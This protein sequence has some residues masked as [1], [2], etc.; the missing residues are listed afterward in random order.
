MDS[1]HLDLCRFWDGVSDPSVLGIHSE[2]P[3]ETLEQNIKD[4]VKLNANSLRSLAPDELQRRPY[5][6][7]EISIWETKHS[8]TKPI[9]LS[10]KVKHYVA[11]LQVKR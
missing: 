8:A 10:R 7:E 4:L 9:A 1:G 2:G 3:S 6:L 5:S 11:T